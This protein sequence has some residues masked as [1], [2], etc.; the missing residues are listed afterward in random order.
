MPALEGDGEAER[1]VGEPGLDRGVAEDVLHVEREEEEQREEAGEGDQ[2][3]DV[4]EAEPVDPEDR[5]RRKRG[6]LPQLV[7]HERREQRTGAGELADRTRAAPA[8]DRRPH[9]RVDEQQ[10]PAG[11]QHRSDRVEVREPAAAPL[12]LD[13]PE[14]GREH[15]RARDRVD[16]HHPPPARAIGQQPAEQDTGG[17]REPTD[18]APDAERRVS[19]LP[20]PELRR[21]DRERGRKRQR[22]AE[23]LGK[24]RA[25]EHA[26]ALASPP[27]SEEVPMSTMPLTRTRRRPSRSASRPPSSM[28]PPYV[29]R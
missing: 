7:E 14:D 19:V 1:Q 12:A 5:Q 21:Q 15:E 25:D 29:S 9:E 11:D 27:T 13:Q 16:E 18:A 22:R 26:R 2:L 17:R 28:K 10:H 24:S 6:P 23:A 20:L 4:R 8:D 3:G